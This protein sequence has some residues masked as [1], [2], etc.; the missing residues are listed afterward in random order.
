MEFGVQSL[1]ELDALLAVNVASHVK[2]TR[3]LLPAM[4]ARRG[5]R[6]CGCAYQQV[7]SSLRF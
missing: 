3:L 7:S 5:R 1:E 6:K 4:L 2:L